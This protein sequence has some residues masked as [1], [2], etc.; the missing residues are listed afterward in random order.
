MATEP[1]FHFD[2]EESEDEYKLPLTTIKCHGRLMSGTTGPLKDFVKPLIDAGGHHI[3]IDCGDLESM[4][5]SG[6]GALVGLKVSA[7]NKGLGKLELVNL[8]PRVRD[9]LKLTSLT[10]LLTK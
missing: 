9:L 8:S 1:T 5:S 2:V 7:I 3:V 10:D 6:L 4:D